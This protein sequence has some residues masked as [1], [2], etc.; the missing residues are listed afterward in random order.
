MNIS[1]EER[2]RK[3]K[4]RRN[5]M[6]LPGE[7]SGYVKYLVREGRLSRPAAAA[8]MNPRK[9]RE[10][11]IAQLNRMYEKAKYDDMNNYVQGMEER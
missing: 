2:I 8:L 10:A 1:R 7:R 11:D 4:L 3:G 6:N 9:W 5:R